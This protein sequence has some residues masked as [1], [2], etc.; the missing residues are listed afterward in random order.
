M[1]IVYINLDRASARR[2][3][4]QA[5]FERYATGGHHLHRFAAFDHDAAGR[6]PIQGKARGAE[7]GCALSHRQVILDH[8]GEEPLMVLED[9]CTFGPTCFHLVDDMTRPEHF[10]W[11]LLFTDICVPEPSLM[12]E[13]ARARPQLVASRQVRGIDITPRTGFAGAPAYIVNPRSLRKVQ[14]VLGH[15]SAIDEPYDMILRRL[16]HRGTLTA[17]FTFPFLTTLS[18]LSED[19]AIQPPES[20]RTDLV[21]N[22][23]RKLM[24][25]DRDLGACRPLLRQIEQH[26]CDEE[27]LLLAPIFCAQAS[28][29]FRRK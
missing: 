2:A 24:W 9:D 22:T 15:L 12:A 4:L 3:A 20:L 7:R 17:G 26:C 25:I 29:G 14:D 27:S 8:V 5:C 10:R 19:S 18:G 28:Q 6:H 23:F 21:W 13:L 11:D 1:K 16:V